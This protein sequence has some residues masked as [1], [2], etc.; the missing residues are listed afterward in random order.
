MSHTS[1]QSVTTELQE[2][3][4]HGGRGRYMNDP[5]PRWPERTATAPL[6]TASGTAPATTAVLARPDRSAP[7]SGV[8]RSW[9]GILDGWC[10]RRRRRLLGPEPGA[11]HPGDPGLPVDHPV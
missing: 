6:Y 5:G 4:A 10:G 7:W 3:A 9:R 11:E 1:G 2:N 8:F